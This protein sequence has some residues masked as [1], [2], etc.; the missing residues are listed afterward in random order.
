MALRCHEFRWAEASHEKKDPGPMIKSAALQKLAA[1]LYPS[2]DNS[3]SGSTPGFATAA[4]L[5]TTANGNIP[6]HEGVYLAEV[7][8]RPRGVERE[9]EGLSGLQR[10]GV[11]GLVVRRRSVRD[12]SEER[13]VGKECRSRWSP[14]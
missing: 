2:I 11:P 10:L 14:Y 3:L 9:G 7:G 13:R 4:D 6:H 8:E 12:R 5:G 1:S